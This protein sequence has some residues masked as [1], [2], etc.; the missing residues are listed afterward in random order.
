MIALPALAGPC[1]R[2]RDYALG[3]LEV[4]SNQSMTRLGALLCFL[5]GGAIALA[6]IGVAGRP[7][8]TEAHADVVKGLASLATVFVAG[9]GVALLKRTKPDELVDPKG[10]TS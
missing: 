2:A 5:I 10:A 1:R 4:Q 9:G 8:L 6:A 3:F 7:H